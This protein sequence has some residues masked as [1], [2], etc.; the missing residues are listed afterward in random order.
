MKRTLGRLILPLFAVV[1]LAGYANRDWLRGYLRPDLVV[2]GSMA[3]AILGPH[4]RQA[5]NECEFAIVS[6]AEVTDLDQRVVCP[7]CGQRQEWRDDTEPDPGART[8]IDTRAPLRRWAVYAYRN[9]ENDLEIKRLIGLAGEHVTLEDGD[10]FVD[11]ERLQ[12]GVRQLRDVAVLVHRQQAPAKPKPKPKP[13]SSDQ[14]QTRAV[15]SRAVPSRAVPSGEASS[16]HRWQSVP[17]GGR[18]AWSPV[19][20]G[21]EFRGQRKRRESAP[22]VYHH[23]LSYESPWPR[24]TP[25]VIQDDY[26]YNA[27]QSRRLHAVNDFGLA[28][29]LAMSDGTDMKCVLATA[30]GDVSVEFVRGGPRGTRITVRHDKNEES[31]S[32]FPHAGPKSLLIGVCDRRLLWE[33]GSRSGAMPL[34]WIPQRE[35]SKRP[36]QFVA[37]GKSAYLSNL[38]IWRDVYYYQPTYAI[39]PQ[40]LQADRL[41]LLGDN[42][43][44]SLDGRFAPQGIPRWRIV[45]RVNIWPSP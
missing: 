15:P 40:R 23:F 10:V 45:G 31:W 35:H 36:V 2:S 22:L 4:Y 16:L 20:T 17:V 1:L 18:T 21:W 42:V 26:A 24:D 28:C 44:I 34:E 9:D 38:R 33:Y 6:G 27:N 13:K 39:S 29:E 14:K 11:G 5:C 7:N 43:P 8:W 41:W 30:A 3:P 37:R 25:A 32:V 12:K 19:A